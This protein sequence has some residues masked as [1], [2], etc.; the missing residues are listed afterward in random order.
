L[1]VSSG[2]VAEVSPLFA[3]PA[4]LFLISIFFD[5]A[6]RRSK[7]R[8][9][10]NDRV[11]IASLARGPGGSSKRSQEHMPLHCF[12]RCEKQKNRGTIKIGTRREGEMKKSICA[13]IAVALAL[14]VAP[15]SGRSDE[16]MYPLD[17]T[18]SWPVEQ[19][20]KAGLKISPEKLLDLKK[21]VAQVAQG[22]SGSFVSDKGL[23]VTNHHVAYG[24]LAR[25]NGT[26]EHKGIMQ[27]GFVAQSMKDEISC[28]GYDLM[29]VVEVRD[30]TGEVEGVLRKGS[31]GHR[32]FEA[33]RLAKEKLE[34]KCQAEEEGRICEADSLDGGRFYHMM[35]YKRIRDVR[36]VY[37]PEEDIGKF[38][39]DVDNWMYPRHTGDYT[40]LRAYV[41][42]KGNGAP[43]SADNV[44]YKPAAHLEVSPDGVKMGD[45]VLVMGFPARTRRNFPS[46]S[47]RYSV[48]QD[49]PLRSEIYKGILD[50]IAEV[51]KKDEQSARR[52]Q[53]LEAGLNN[54]VKYYEESEAGFEK[55]KVVDKFAEREKK[56]EEALKDGERARDFKLVLEEIDK[57]YGRYGKVY[58]RHFFLQRLAW[59]VRSLGTAYDIARWTEERTKPDEDRKDA[60]YKNKNVYRVFE[61][62]DRLDDQITIPAERAILT[63][64]LKDSEKLP[65]N[66]RIRSV[67]KFLAWGKR[68]AK[69]V[70]KEAAKAKKDF[71][72]Y[73]EE[74]T[75]AKPSDDPVETAVDLAYA[76]TKLIARDA[77]AGE[78]DRA[79]FQRRSLFYNEPEEA[80][81][82]KDP[83]LDFA[84]DL[85]KEKKAIDEGPYR[86]I[87]EIFDTELRPEF[88]EL[89]EAPYPDANFQLRLSFGKVDDY[90]AAA[91][92][93]RHR[94]LTD[95]KGVIA[96]DKGEYPFRVPSKLKEAAQ[97][98][99]GR[100]YDKNIGDIPVNFTT[101]LDTTGGNSGS[102]VLDAQGRLVGLLFDGTPESILSDW[103]FLPDSQRSICLDIR[104][105]LFLAD[106]VHGADNILKEMGF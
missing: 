40:F 91:D 84:R 105:A 89:I 54:A 64:L 66:E 58:K 33:I 71:A 88:A 21:A 106:K 96:K 68:E 90:T 34:K 31:K 19:M 86:A 56:V 24:C 18:G 14:G 78:L 76:R 30:I 35:V 1:L 87:E 41:D 51:G 101:T 67:K 23:L 29:V 43:Y 16:G 28:P 25:L 104:Y 6:G 50:I 63:Y 53:G 44:L 69:K 59:M 11:G 48:E 22:G 70:K 46:A 52:Y 47:A 85:A 98:D 39:G 5:G 93:K 38:G 36:L 27:K 82:F 72:Q 100:F 61:G 8:A 103:Q 57:Q 9:L 75:R 62:S 80:R 92:G 3:H 95:L 102:P 81:R 83:L 17:Q 10:W 94:Y 99:I 12:M 4:E 60:E 79:L 26:D 15:Q 13:S 2:I 37:A 73:Y 45:L 32:R 74:L 97:G 42:A 7:R 20:K 65:K 55:W 77:A 49:M